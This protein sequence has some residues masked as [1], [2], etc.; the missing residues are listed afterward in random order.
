MICIGPESK[1]DGFLRAAYGDGLMKSLAAKLTIEFGEG[2]TASNLFNMR[3]FYLAFPKFYTLRR[4]LSW[5]HYRILMR[6]ENKE[7]RN[8]YFNECAES[9]WST[10]VLQRQIDTHIEN[11]SIPD[12]ATLS[13]FLF[14][15]VERK[16]SRV[17]CLVHAF[18]QRR[19]IAR[20]FV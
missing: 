5:S 2:F 9:R 20:I 10:R 3:Q 14:H 15:V 17:T 4:E 6:I 1:A 8:Y 12:F 16:Y 13:F 18:F 11:V 19:Q 7:A